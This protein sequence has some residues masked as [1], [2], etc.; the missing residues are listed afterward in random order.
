MI[1]QPRND[2]PLRLQDKI[3]SII[4]FGGFNNRKFIPIYFSSYLNRSLLFVEYFFI[5]LFIN[6]LFNNNDIFVIR[7]ENMQQINQKI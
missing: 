1:N 6:L 7:D 4:C 2:D 3:N 5:L